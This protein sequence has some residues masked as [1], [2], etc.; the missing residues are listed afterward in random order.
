MQ[1]I[2][3]GFSNANYANTFDFLQMQI[4]NVQ[5]YFNQDIYFSNT[6]IYILGTTLIR[7]L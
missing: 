3:S 7:K 5:K 2:L 6:F 1:I 4:Q